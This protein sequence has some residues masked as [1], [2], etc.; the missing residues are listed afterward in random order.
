MS[1]IRIFSFCHQIQVFLLG[2][3]CQLKKCTNSWVSQF[4][5]ELIWRDVIFDIGVKTYLSPPESLWEMCQEG[6]KGILRGTVES[7]VLMGIVLMCDLKSV[8]TFS[9]IC[10]LISKL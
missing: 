4:A 8:V 5:A 1:H 10:L 2:S 9:N 3:I 7:S 6:K